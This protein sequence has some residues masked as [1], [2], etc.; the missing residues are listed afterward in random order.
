MNGKYEIHR[1]QTY[2]TQQCVKDW[3]DLVER[4]FHYYPQTKSVMDGQTD[5]HEDPY[6]P[7]DSRRAGG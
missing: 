4:Y 5:G 7:S 3:K 2:S 1:S 6:I